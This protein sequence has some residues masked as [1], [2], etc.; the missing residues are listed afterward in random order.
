MEPYVSMTLMSTVDEECGI[1]SGG[2]R[3]ETTGS[4]PSMLSA[5]DGRDIHLRVF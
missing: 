2:G 1:W 3:F 4:V 5:L